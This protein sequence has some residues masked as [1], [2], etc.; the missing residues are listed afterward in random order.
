MIRGDFVGELCCL[1]TV[2]VISS[3]KEKR[4]T[5]VGE[6]SVRRCVLCVRVCVC[7]CVQ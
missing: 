3:G 4:N 5:S 1:L 7:A 6:I 2:F